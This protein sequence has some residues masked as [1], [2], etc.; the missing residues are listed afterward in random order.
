VFIF[1]KSNISINIQ[2]TSNDDNNI[3]ISLSLRKTRKL[4]CSESLRKEKNFFTCIFPSSYSRARHLF[5][6][7]V[8]RYSSNDKDTNLAV[9][10]PFLHAKVLF[11][12][13]D[14]LFYYRSKSWTREVFREI[15]VFKCFIACTIW[16][17][18]IWRGNWN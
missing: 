14:N 15:V 8:R 12:L 7:R 10:N 2:E 18:W 5:I 6:F 13:L 9:Y 1:T 3:T 16:F 4:S 11:S 17:R